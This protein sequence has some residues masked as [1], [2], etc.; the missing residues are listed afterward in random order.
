M[1]KSTKTTATPSRP[2]ATPRKSVSVKVP[3]TA[4]P[5]DERLAMQRTI[6]APSIRAVN[7][8]A[9]STPQP[10]KDELDF[11]D[12]MAVLHEQ[13]KAVHSGDLSHAETMLINQAVAL[14]GVFSSLIGKAMK[15]EYMQNIESF[16][17]MALRAQNQCRTT[18]ETLAT[19]KQGPV[20]FARQAN[21]AH[22]HQQVNNGTDQSPEAQSNPP[23]AGGGRAGASKN[24]N[25]S[26]ELLEAKQNG[27][28]TG[29]QGTTSGADPEMATVGKI[30]R[31]ADG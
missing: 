17:R 26:N 9:A 27:L 7:V 1:T 8:I 10:F 16:M 18:L 6:V 20:V 24:Q 11:T 22:G 15:Q 2:R 30:D 31:T 19:I 21:I 5:E 3:P 29:A 14:E 23:Q 13:A 12:M 4:T 28:D 25:E